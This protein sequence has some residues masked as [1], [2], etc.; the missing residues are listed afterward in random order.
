[1]R[2]SVTVDLALYIEEEFIETLVINGLL[3]KNY[4]YVI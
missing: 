2:E 4:N 1:M 3:E